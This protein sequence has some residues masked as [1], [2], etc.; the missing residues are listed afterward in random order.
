M[1]TSNPLSS[2]K[3]REKASQICA[4]YLQVDIVKIN[5]EFCSLAKYLHFREFGDAFYLVN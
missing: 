4:E 2:E 1:E 5:G 3:V